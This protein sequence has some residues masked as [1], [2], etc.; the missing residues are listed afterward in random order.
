MFEVK[1]KHTSEYMLKLGEDY[2]VKVKTETA[3]EIVRGRISKVED[4]IKKW[5]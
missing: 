3:L 4:D 2:Y 5:K 1:I